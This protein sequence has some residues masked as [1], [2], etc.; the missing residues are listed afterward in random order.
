MSKRQTT[1]IPG[2]PFWVNVR[3]E[4]IDAGVRE[5]SR[6]CAVALA[7]QERTGSPAGVA[8]SHVIMGGRGTFSLTN[9][10]LLPS[11]AIEWIKAFDAGVKSYPF[12]FQL[13]IFP[14]KPERREG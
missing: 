14:A 8:R 5:D 2:K 11:T 7:I 9:T 1:F 10:I 12:K 6:R 13:T 4:H 3:Q